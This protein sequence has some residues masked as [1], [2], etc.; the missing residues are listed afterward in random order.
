MNDQFE[1]MA[2]TNYARHAQAAMAA[3]TEK[4]I[5]GACTVTS[6]DTVAARNVRIE[7]GLSNL[8]ENITS[9]ERALDTVLRPA[10]TSQKAESNAI[11]SVDGDACTLAGTGRR[12]AE[13]IEGA[14]A[15]VNDLL[16]R[17]A[18]E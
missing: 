9:L 1:G 8:H 5:Q 18:L 11:R 7:Q 12:F 3:A 6:T 13:G 15:R 4:Y 17:L 16:S 14:N 10:T 2:N